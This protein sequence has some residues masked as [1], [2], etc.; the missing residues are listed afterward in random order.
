MAEHATA[1][2]VQHEVPQRFVLRDEARLLPDRVAGRWRDAADDDVADLA[3]GVAA[4]D[5]NDI[6]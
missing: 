4:Y 3:F 1:G 2:L 6:G 5:M